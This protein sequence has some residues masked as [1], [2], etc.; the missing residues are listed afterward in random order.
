MISSRLV[1]RLD[2]TNYDSA[3]FL[4]FTD[5][6]SLDITSVERS[7]T[8]ITAIVTVR[9][10]N[11]ADHPIASDGRSLNELQAESFGAAPFSNN[12]RLEYEIT[13]GPTNDIWQLKN[14]QI[15]AVDTAE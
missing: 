11:T 8:I 2:G 14:L 13:V 9:E 15:R 3:E 6:E 7:G 1:D 10:K 5:I 12:D 4:V